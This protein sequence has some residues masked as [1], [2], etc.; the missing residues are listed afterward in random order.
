MGSSKT[1]VITVRVSNE[2]AAALRLEAERAG[3]DIK[4]LINML[5][6]DISEGRIRCNTD[7]FA[8]TDDFMND[9]G[10][11]DV[12]EYEELGFAGVLRL[13]RKNDYPDNVIRKMNEQNMIQISDAGRYNPRKFRDEAC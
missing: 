3:K 8:P 1:T 2:A 13:M 6:M 10:T 4:E 9:I 11:D 5:G 7:S 12:Y